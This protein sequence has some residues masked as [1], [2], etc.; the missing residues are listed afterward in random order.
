MTLLASIAWTHVRTRIRQTMVGIFAVVTGVGFTIMM[1]GL[2][3]GS[4]IDFIRQLVDVMPHVLVT[5][6]Y[7]S[8][9]KQPAEQMYAAVQMAKV[10]NVNRRSG[11]SN[12]NSVMASLESWLDGAVVPTVE[13]TAIVDH[14]GDR[15]GITVL[16]ID[17]L[18]EGRVSKLP[19]Q[20]V[21]GAMADLSKSSNGVIIGEA[22]ARKIAVKHRGTIL[23][24]GGEGV[25]LTATVVGIFR[26]GVKQI[27]EGQIYSQKSMAQI[28]FGQS[29]GIN[30]LRIRLR[31]PLAAR[32]VASQVELQTGY[33]AVSWQEA[34]SDLLSSFKTRDFIT[35][36]IMASMLLA[37]SFGTYNIIST[38]TYEKRHDIAIMKSI[39]MQEH[40]VRRIFIIEAAMIGSVGIFGG[41]ILGYILCYAMSQI[42]FFN[43][44]SGQT[45]PL[46]VHYSVAQ[47]TVTGGISLACCTLAAFFPARK[48]TRS[49]PVDIIRGAS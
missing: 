30:Q 35:L 23:L 31:D 41:W 12:P 20:M 38:I 32:N 49:N 47:Y 40:W 17:P 5:D 2:M 9:P 33:K 6:E 16:G 45:V 26:S 13:T 24:S 39:G 34:N 11:I 4:Q 14:H 18:A 37:S 3:Q 48:A 15:I 28:F 1:A 46:P 19:S 43:P 44:F 7:R 29:G 25:R 21:Q 22:L 8:P 36:A 10:A 42:T 27:D